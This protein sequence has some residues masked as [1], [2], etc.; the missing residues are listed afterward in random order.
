MLLSDIKMNIIK[1][2]GAVPIS[3]TGGGAPQRTGKGSEGLPYSALTEEALRVRRSRVRLPGS[4]FL[5]KLR[6]PLELR[7]DCGSSS[8][9][10]PTRGIRAVKC[11]RDGF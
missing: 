8:K 6:V 3:K 9:E 10:T 7:E 2:Q 1:C 11:T 5:K 4:F